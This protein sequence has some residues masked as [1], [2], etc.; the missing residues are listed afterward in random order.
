MPRGDYWPHWRVRLASGYTEADSG[1]HEWNGSKNNKGYGVIWLEGK[2]RLAHRA[3]WFAAYGEW[4]TPGLVVDHI[5]E[6]K[7]CMRLEHLRLLT[8]GENIMR[9]YP[10]G[11]AKTEDRRARNR[12]AK[13]RM[14]Q[15]RLQKAGESHFVV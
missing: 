2:L 13:A 6:N 4:P 8:N 10:R 14:K 7:S 5:C 9:A 12:A 1:C 15:R 3:A 11:D